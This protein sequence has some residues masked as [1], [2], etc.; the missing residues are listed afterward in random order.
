[1]GLHTRGTAK[2]RRGSACGEKNINNNR[3]CTYYS[4]R[5]RNAYA[6]KVN[7]HNHN[8]HMQHVQSYYMR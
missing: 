5:T 1:M 7:T 3:L 6:F 8:T 2:K 4:A